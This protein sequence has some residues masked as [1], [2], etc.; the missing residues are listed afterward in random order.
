[1]EYLF[2]VKSFINSIEDNKYV[3]A[4]FSNKEKFAIIY[5]KKLS[6]DITSRWDLQCINQNIIN[7][8]EEFLKE[9]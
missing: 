1:R 8:T 2:N 7:N 4:T 5:M 9:K 6:F 3:N